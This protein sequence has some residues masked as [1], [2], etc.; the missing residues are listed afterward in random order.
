MSG[1]IH[2]PGVIGLKYIQFHFHSLFF[3]YSFFS[4]FIRIKI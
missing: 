4:T 1:I 2:L 3:Y